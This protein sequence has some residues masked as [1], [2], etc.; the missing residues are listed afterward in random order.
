MYSKLNNV[1]MITSRMMRWTGHVTSIDEKSS[2]Y[3]LFVGN[4]KERDHQ[5]M[6]ST[7]NIAAFHCHCY[8]PAP[9]W[10]SVLLPLHSRIVCSSWTDYTLQ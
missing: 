9:F 6:H 2:S 7:S 10:L 1:R 5:L 3:R 4:M 8:T